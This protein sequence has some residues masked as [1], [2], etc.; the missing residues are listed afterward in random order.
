MG[1]GVFVS[2]ER[3]FCLGTKV[4]DYS[5]RAKLCGVHLSALGDQRKEI[6][7]RTERILQRK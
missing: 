7:M 5:V 2:K 1:C 4:S 6:P 3:T